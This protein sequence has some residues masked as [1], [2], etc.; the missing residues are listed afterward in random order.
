MSDA[1]QSNAFSAIGHPAPQRT[2]VSRLRHAINLFAAPAIWVAQMSLSEIIASNACAADMKPMPFLRAH[3]SA[4]L[5]IVNLDCLLL[6]AACGIFAWRSW[7]VTRRELSRNH[8]HAADV[9]EGRTRFL[10]LLGLMT[11]FG[12]TVA[13]LF[14]ACAFV[15]VSPC[16]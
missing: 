12:F 4:L 14:T 13:A 2:R 7:Q 6:T 3:V 11:S 16:V 10:T 9:G 5:A 15:L 8:G 1:P